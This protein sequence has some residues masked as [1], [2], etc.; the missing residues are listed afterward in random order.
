[1]KRSAARKKQDSVVPKKTLTASHE[2]LFGSLV[3]AKIRVGVVTARFN[4]DVTSRLEEGALRKLSELGVPSKNIRVASVPGAVE[5]TTAAKALFNSGVD[6]VITLGCI[7]RGETTHYEMVC[8]AVERGCTQ[9][10]LE[11]GKPVVFGV[12]TTENEEQAFARL[13]GQHGH[14]GEEAAEVAVEMVNLLKAIKKS[15]R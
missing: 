10:Q 5:I 14:K 15:K 8:A 7:I 2:V 12:L 13:G 3:G 6:V 11:T 4:S 9:L 1:M